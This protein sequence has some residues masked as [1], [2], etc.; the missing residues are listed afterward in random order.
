MIIF[1]NL[2]F[3]ISKFYLTN[4]IRYALLHSIVPF[5][6]VTILRDEDRIVKLYYFIL[7]LQIAN[8]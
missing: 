7:M 4:F 5:I 3:L 8:F 6:A 1:F 2:Q